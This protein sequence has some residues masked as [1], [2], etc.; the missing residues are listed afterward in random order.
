MNKKILMVSS[1]VLFIFSLIV[2]CSTNSEEP[3]SSKES[4]NETVSSNKSTNETEQNKSPERFLANVGTGSNTG[5]VYAFAAAIAKIVSDQHPE[6][7]LTV[8]TSGGGKENLARMVENRADF[9]FAYGPNI[10]SAIKGLDEYK[11]QEEKYSTIR[12]IFSWPYAAIQ[13]IVRDDSGIKTIQDLKGKSFSVGAPGSTGAT[14]VWPYVL[15][16]FGVTEENSD[17]QYLSTSASAQALG[18]GAIVATSALSKGKVGHFETLSLT[19][20]VR[21]LEIP[22]PY[23]ENIIANSPGLTKAEQKPDLYGENQVNDKPIPTIGMSGTFLVNADVP[24]E[25]VYNI[26]KA[27]FENITEFHKSHASAKDINL[28]TAIKDMSVPLHPGAEKYFKE[29]GVLND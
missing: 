18:D 20:K 9:G 5:T 4:T 29:V 21:L 12:G 11:G 10:V 15:P 19:K 16:E 22:D 6:I 7:Q 8:Q 1:I 27:L 25:V 28:E 13:L 14:F 3:V 26:T 24:D 17:W 23:R 2:G